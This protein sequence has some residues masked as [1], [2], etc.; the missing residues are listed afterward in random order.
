MLSNRDPGG[1]VEKT[2]FRLRAAGARLPSQPMAAASPGGCAS[3]AFFVLR[4]SRRL[5]G[6]DYSTHVSFGVDVPTR[7]E[8]EAV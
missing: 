4:R 1:G 6:C 7:S 8:R 5:K 2:R 3:S